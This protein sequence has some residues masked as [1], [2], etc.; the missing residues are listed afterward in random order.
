MYWQHTLP[1]KHMVLLTESLKCSHM[2]PPEHPLILHRRST[3]I[4]ERLVGAADPEMRIW[5]HHEP[6]GTNLAWGF[7]VLRM[8]TNWMQ[9]LVK[10]RVPEAGSEAIRRRT[11]DPLQSLCRSLRQAPAG[12]HSFAWATVA[13]GMPLYV[14]A[15]VVLFC[16]T[17]THYREKT[18]CGRVAGFDSVAELADALW[19]SAIAEGLSIDLSLDRRVITLSKDSAAASC[20]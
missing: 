3:G 11:A 8:E 17:K 10:E 19:P 15:N 6:S 4:A 14:Q 13:P 1:S 12:Y 2:L 20:G 18:L 7:K 16:C 5:E 9:C